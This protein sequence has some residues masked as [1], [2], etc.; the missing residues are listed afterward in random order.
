MNEILTVYVRK[1]KVYV[2]LIKVREFAGLDV[3][4]VVKL[5]IKIYRYIQRNVANIRRE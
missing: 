5:S 1:R 2:D 3:L 4:E